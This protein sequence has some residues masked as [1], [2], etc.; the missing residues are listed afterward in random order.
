MLPWKGLLEEVVPELGLATPDACQA[1][2]NRKEVGRRGKD[3]KS[4][5]RRACPGCV[6]GRRVAGRSSFHTD[7]TFHALQAEVGAGD[8]GQPGH[9]QLRRQTST[10]RSVGNHWELETTEEHDYIWI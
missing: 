7:C 4:P 2:N 1:K 10:S 8:H 3:T 5:D 6:L 9:V